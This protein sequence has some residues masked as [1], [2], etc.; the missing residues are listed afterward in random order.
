MGDQYF[1]ENAE[2]NAIGVLDQR[3]D[4]AHPIVHFRGIQYAKIP[5]RFAA[6]VPLV[7]DG[8]TTLK[9]TQYG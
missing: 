3:F 5:E 7:R 4:E 6:P 9:A 8:R 2:A 1:F